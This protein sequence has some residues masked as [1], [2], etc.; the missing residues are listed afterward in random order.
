MMYFCHEES[1]VHRGTLHRCHWL[2]DFKVLHY[3]RQWCIRRNQWSFFYSNDVSLYQESSSLVWDCSVC[4]PISS[5]LNYMWMPMLFGNRHHHKLS[6]RIIPS[7]SSFT[8]TS[9]TGRTSRVLQWNCHGRFWK[10]LV[11]LT[12]VKK[13][14]C[15]RTWSWRDQRSVEFFNVRVC[16][17][18]G[19]ERGIIITFLQNYVLSL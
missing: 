19:L 11:W 14:L 8:S 7:S 4:E 3:G 12:T 17:H 9:Y 18:V 13:H 2:L 10:G 15:M 6:K 5:Q 1:N 16:V